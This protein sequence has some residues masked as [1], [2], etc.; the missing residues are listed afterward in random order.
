MAP[1]RFE[2]Y[3]LP[4]YV[5]FTKNI[6]IKSCSIYFFRRRTLL[7]WS[8]ELLTKYDFSYLINQRMKI[9]ANCTK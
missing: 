5:F 1:N 6:S 2:W 9:K 8:Q 4:I 7:K 3:R